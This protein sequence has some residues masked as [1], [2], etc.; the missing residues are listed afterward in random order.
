MGTGKMPVYGHVAPL[1]EFVL[2]IVDGRSGLQAKGI[3]AEVGN[4]ISQFVH[5]TVE[6]VAEL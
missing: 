1:T 2:D 4:R 3:A 6:P 5:R